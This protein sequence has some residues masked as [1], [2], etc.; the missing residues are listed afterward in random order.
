MQGNGNSNGLLYNKDVLEYIG[1][2]LILA[3]DISKHIV[4]CTYAGCETFWFLGGEWE[5]KSLIPIDVMKKLIKAVRIL[6]YV[7]S[8]IPDELGKVEGLQDI[9][10]GPCRLCLRERKLEAYR[11]WQRGNKFPECFGSAGH[12]CSREKCAEDPKWN[13]SHPCTIH[14][15]REAMRR[16]RMELLIHGKEETEK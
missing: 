8:V 10:H 13:C 7:K 1:Q 16:R 11:R 12:F 14:P 3:G 2:F 9:S 5:T 15:E 6:N 4:Q